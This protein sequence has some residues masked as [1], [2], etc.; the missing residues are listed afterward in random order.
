MESWGSVESIFLENTDTG[1]PALGN[2]QIEWLDFNADGNA[3]VI[4][5]GN[6]EG[7]LPIFDIYENNG[8]STF[9]LL[10]FLSRH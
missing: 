7:G 1:I 6:D 10:G 9:L 4:I 3:D 8:N 5:S 2:A